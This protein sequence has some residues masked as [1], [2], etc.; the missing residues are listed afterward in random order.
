MLHVSKKP[1]AP[2]LFN[3]F[4]FQPLKE[5]FFPL[6]SIQ[7][8]HHPSLS[9]V[10]LFPSPPNSQLLFCFTAFIVWDLCTHG[11]SPGFALC[12]PSAKTHKTN[13]NITCSILT[14][15]LLPIS[16]L[17]NH[18]LKGMLHYFLPATILPVPLKTDLEKNL[19]KII[20]NQ[21]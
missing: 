13:F 5:T 4:I 11:F 19:R 2:F 10:I 15:L 6:T 18:G 17:C 9:E 16:N 1:G 3:C 20:F 21:S 8:Q 7:G 14:L 12:H